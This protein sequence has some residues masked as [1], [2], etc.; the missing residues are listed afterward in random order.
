MPWHTE[1]DAYTTASDLS[2]IFGLCLGTRNWMPIPLLVTC[3]RSLVY[4]LARGTEYLYH[5]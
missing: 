5:C 2:A 1:L 3:R 4:A